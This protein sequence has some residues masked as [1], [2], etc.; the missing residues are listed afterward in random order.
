M[1]L[2]RCSSVNPIFYSKTDTSCEE[3]QPPISSPD[4]NQTLRG[5]TEWAREYAS[6]NPSKLLMPFKINLYL[7]LPIDGTF[8]VIFLLWFFFC[9]MKLFANKT[10]TRHISCS[11]PSLDTVYTLVILV[12]AFQGPWQQYPQASEA[13]APASAVCRVLCGWPRGCLFSH[14]H[15]AQ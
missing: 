14:Y 7:F 1:H 3:S 15:S 4:F 11:K 12:K 6:M 13:R 8:L 5:I 9:F 10:N 2:P